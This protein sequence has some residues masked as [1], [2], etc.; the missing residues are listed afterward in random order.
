MTPGDKVKISELRAGDVFEWKGNLYQKDAF[1]KPL[2]VWSF[3]KL[4]YHG[5]FDNDKVTYL[6][7]LTAEMVKDILKK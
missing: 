3:N 6:G 5:M 4:H 1:I 7:P 2:K